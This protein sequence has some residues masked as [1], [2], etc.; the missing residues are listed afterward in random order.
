MNKLPK[1]Q[2][3]AR[4]RTDSRAGREGAACAVRDRRSQAA[5]QVTSPCGR[6]TLAYE[7]RTVSNASARTAHICRRRN[8]CAQEN[9][10]L[11]F[12]QLRDEGPSEVPR[13]TRAQSVALA[14]HSEVL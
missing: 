3:G 14:L 12:H 8:P 5:A 1:S 13:R 6:L 7:S 9:S 11:R 10:D 2:A 4:P